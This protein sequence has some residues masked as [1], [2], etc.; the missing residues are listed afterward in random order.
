M[1]LSLRLPTSR[2]RPRLHHCVS[3]PLFR[4]TDLLILPH[5]LFHHPLPLLSRLLILPLLLLL[6]RPLRLLVLKQLPRKSLCDPSSNR[7]DVVLLLLVEE[8]HAARENLALDEL[9]EREEVVGEELGERGEEVVVVLVELD[10]EHGDVGEEGTEARRE[11]ALDR[12]VLCGPPVVSGWKAA[13][14]KDRTLGNLD[15][16]LVEL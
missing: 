16:E 1:L 14:E 9:L 12:K 4:R 15:L 2:R 10:R 5:T 11:L 13:R 6:P 3:R 8:L 7:I